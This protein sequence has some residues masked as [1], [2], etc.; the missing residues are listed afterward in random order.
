[1]RDRTMK[2]QCFATGLGKCFD[3][4]TR[5]RRVPRIGLRMFVEEFFDRAE[6]DTSLPII[7]IFRVC[8]VGPD[9]FHQFF[10]IFNFW[11]KPFVI[12]KICGKGFFN[13]THVSA[14]TPGNIYSRPSMRGGLKQEIGY[15]G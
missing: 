12:D 13:Q 2:D 8:G 9:Q 7:G 11:K 5:E 4:N 15:E 6:S 10:G 14:A 3:V 1:M